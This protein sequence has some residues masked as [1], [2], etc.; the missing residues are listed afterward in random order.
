MNRSDIHIVLIE[1]A[2]SLNIG[3]VARA[4]TNL[5]FDN[6]HLVNPVAYDPRRAKV[7]ACWGAPLLDKAVLHSRIEDVLGQ[8]QEVVGFSIRAGKNR[9]GFLSLPDWASTILAGSSARTALLFGPEDNGLRQE[10]IEH[11]RY[12]IRIP[13][14]QEYP[15]MNLAQSV[16]VALYEL[17][18]LDPPQTVDQRQAPDWNQ[19]YQLDR[20]LDSVGELSGFYGKGTAP[21]V[22]GVMKNLF[23][24]MKPD[25]REVRLMLGLLG[26]LDGIL[27]GKIPVE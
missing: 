25:E 12:L 9:C 13:T 7:T 5:G 21:Q 19:F 6:L 10:H 14:S 23:R 1:A 2:D 16:V 4:M 27:K 26:R 20:L 3:A 18:R 24:R 17:S 8:M 11:C 22:P 15:T